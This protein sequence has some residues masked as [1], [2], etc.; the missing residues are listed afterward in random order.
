MDVFSTKRSYM[1]KILFIIY[2]L[3]F[4]GATYNHAMDLFTYGLFPYQRLNT[5]VPLWLNIYWTV[6]TLIDP[7]AMALL[8]YCID[9]GLVLYGVVIISDVY[10]NL[11]SIKFS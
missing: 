1:V 5:S 7:L 4:L 6:L 11:N 3:S 9:I 2:L 10:I 8:L